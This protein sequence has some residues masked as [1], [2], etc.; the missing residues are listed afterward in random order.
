MLKSVLGQEVEDDRDRVVN[1]KKTE[2]VKI[3][4][5]DTPS[6]E[7]P[8]YFDTTVTWH[9]VV[10]TIIAV[11]ANGTIQRFGQP[12]ENTCDWILSNE[13]YDTWSK[14]ATGSAVL[15]IQ[16]QKGKIRS[17]QLHP[18]ADTRGC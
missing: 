18:T 7:P 15:F 11:N 9:S 6:P 16:G 2:D 4:A 12:V 17:G 13:T 5:V 10:A 1:L 3:G 14:E 8:S